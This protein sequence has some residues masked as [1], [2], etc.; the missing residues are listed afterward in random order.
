MF[1]RAGRRESPDLEGTL[2]TLMKLREVDICNMMSQKYQLVP[3]T[4][5]YLTGLTP[6]LY[7]GY[8]LISIFSRF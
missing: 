8:T 5:L 7:I 4:L 6:K 3:E 2:R 1:H